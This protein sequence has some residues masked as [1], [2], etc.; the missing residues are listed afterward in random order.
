MLDHSDSNAPCYIMPDACD[1]DIGAVLL[2]PGR[3]ISCASRKL[4]ASELS[5]SIVEKELLATVESLDKW[6]YMWIYLKTATVYTD[7]RPLR[8][9]VR[10][11]KGALETS[12]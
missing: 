7:H 4:R 5:M 6:F 9:M 8:H 11:I 1:E 12:K 3:I 2:K 10:I